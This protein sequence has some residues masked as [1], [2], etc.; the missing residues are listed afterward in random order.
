MS[1]WLEI[2][3]YSDLSLFGQVLRMLNADGRTSFFFTELKIEIKW[4]PSCIM[5]LHITTNSHITARLYNIRWG[6][7]NIG[8]K[9]VWNTEFASSEYKFLAFRC[10]SSL[11]LLETIIFNVFAFILCPKWFH[12]IAMPLHANHGIILGLNFADV[13]TSRSRVVKVFFSTHFLFSFVLVNYF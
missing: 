5:K 12:F 1:N 13:M 2:A 4:E 9:I 10:W 3:D 11:I 7:R 6:F 8:R